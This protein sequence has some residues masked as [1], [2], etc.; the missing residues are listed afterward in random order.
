MP[1]RL[2]EFSSQE[3]RR[4]GPMISDSGPRELSARARMNLPASKSKI[5]I[6]PLNPRTQ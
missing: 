5:H 3:G 4:A 2:M 1:A 6:E